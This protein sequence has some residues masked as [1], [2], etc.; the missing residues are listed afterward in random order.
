MTRVGLLRAGYAALGVAILSL[1]GS[2]VPSLGWLI[3]ASALLAFVGATLLA[4]SQDEFPKWAGLTFIAYAALTFLVFMAATPATIRLKFWSGFFNA[5]PSPVWA[6]LQ[7]YLLLALPL[8]ITA[9][10]LVAA[11]ER[12]HGPRLLLFGSLAGVIAVAI[13]TVALN[14]ATAASNDGDDENPN[15]TERDNTP[16]ILRAHTQA[17]SQAGLLNVLLALSTGAG[18]TGALWAAWRPDEYH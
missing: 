10:A 7:E 6:A 15:T 17:T 12:E 13:L 11:W 2:F 14:P 5:A 1:V 4:F 18:A 16:D 8:M 9:T 3:T